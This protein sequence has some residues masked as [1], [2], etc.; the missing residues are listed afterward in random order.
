MRDEEVINYE[1]LVTT[2]VLQSPAGD[3]MEIKS[4]NLYAVSE[5]LR[6]MS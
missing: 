4:N 6:K 3:T 1:W 2:L 5:L